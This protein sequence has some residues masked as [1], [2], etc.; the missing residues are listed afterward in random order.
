VSV[1]NFGCRLNGAE[2]EA[3]AHLLGTADGRLV[4][5][6]CAVTVEAERQAR[7]AIRRAHREDPARP[8]W[9]TG[10]AAEIAP[11]SWAA[12]SCPSRMAATTAAPSASSPSVV[13]P[14]AA[15]RLTPC[16]PRGSV[17]LTRAI[18]SWC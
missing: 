5:N 4:V 6:T 13:A 8:I 17:S 16:S 2:S 15:C 18:A 9:V 12:P 3:I 7:Q 10:C 11:D 1:L 14:R